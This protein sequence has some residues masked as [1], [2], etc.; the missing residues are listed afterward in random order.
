MKECVLYCA[1]FPCDYEFSRDTLVWSWTAAGLIKSEQNGDVGAV[2]IRCFERLMQLK[3]ILHSGY[4]HLRDQMMYKLGNDKTEFLNKHSLGVQHR[5]GLDSE[6]DVEKIQH[7]SLIF[8]GIDKINFDILRNSRHLKTLL[9]HQCSGSGLENLLHD[10]LLE[11]KSLT[12]LDL[13]CTEIVELPSSLEFL[14][15]LKYLDLSETPIR[16]LPEWTDSLCNL[17]T[18]ILVGCLNLCGL[19]KCMYKM[20]KLQHLVLDIARQLQSMPIGMGKLTNLQTLSAFL[21]GKKDGNR[22]TQLRNMNKLKGSLSILKLENILNKDEARDARLHDKLHL[23]KLDFV[24]SNLQ[25]AKITSEEEIL[26]HLQPHFG[27]QELKIVSYGG[28][29][30]PSWI[31]D[32]SFT[33]ITS[34]TLY[35][36]R[37]CERLPSLGEL[38][39]LKI[40]NIV[41]MDEL[42]VI[43]RLFYQQQAN[44]RQNAF[45]RLEKLSFDGMSNLEIW[46]GIEEGH[47]PCLQLLMIGFCP[48]L[49]ALPSLSYLNS[50]LHLEICDCP[51]LPCLPEGRLPSSLK[52]LMMKDCPK[53]KERCYSEQGEIGQGYECSI[54][55]Q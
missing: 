49:T 18:L 36:C 26:E 50:L 38:P 6:T 12:I 11:L 23:T 2:A 7:L 13:S 29:S 17:E 51:K 52:C 41:D 28:G 54:G 31:S 1:L 14:K 27:L 24:W 19:P 21:V 43:D 33:Q 46:T 48:R 42:V 3:Y 39:S 40:L 47:F 5:N 25:D 20:I 32:P 53:L 44:Q 10:V 30:L 37:Y 55:G 15:G 8:E 45:P 16:R 4:D 35:G 22:I 34:I 9:L